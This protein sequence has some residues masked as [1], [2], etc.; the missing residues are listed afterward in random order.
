MIGKKIHQLSVIDSTNDEATRRA[1]EGAEEGEIF[2]A[3]EQ[4]AGRGRLNRPWE[5]PRGRNLYLS[6]IL[7][8]PI[9]PYEAPLLTLMAASA[10]FDTLSPLLPEK[11]KS[12]L[13]IKW[14]NDLY[15][16][17]KKI[18]GILCEMKAEGNRLQW[19]VC[20]IGLNINTTA[21]DFSPDL[22]STATSLKIEA[23]KTLDRGL[24]LSKLL[25]ALEDRYDQF[26]ERGPVEIISFCERHSSLKGQ[27]V[28]WH[29]P[30]GEIRGVVKGLDT[31][32]ALILHTADG[33][34]LIVTAG[35]VER[36]VS[37]RSL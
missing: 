35:D 32:G 34:R 31:Q 36:D 17:G 12:T 5:S 22:R 27:K 21:P 18:A 9:K 15:L 8:P 3:E 25:I 29:S 2:L 11:L 23:Q 28:L 37:V 16:N 6:C 30:T 20:G 26:L 33:K 10:L 13:K 4:T 14:P 7:R 1:Q 19:V 24:I